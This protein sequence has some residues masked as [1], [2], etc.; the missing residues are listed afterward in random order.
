M[1]TERLTTA[2]KHNPFEDMQS[3][4]QQSQQRYND[5]ALCFYIAKRDLS[6]EAVQRGLNPET[7]AKW[8]AREA[9]PFYEAFR[10]ARS[11]ADQ[12][13]EVIT[14]DQVKAVTA[15][16]DALATDILRLTNQ[17]GSLKLPASFQGRMREGRVDPQAVLSEYETM[18]QHAAAFKKTHRFKVGHAGRDQHSQMLADF[19]EAD[20]RDLPLLENRNAGEFAEAVVARRLGISTSTVHKKLTEARRAAGRSR[21]KRRVAR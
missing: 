3:D 20:I 7:F 19:I 6:H 8:V 21:V 2:R 9:A 15:W 18:F 13:P 1:P 17:L 11:G 10:R 4:F 12:L 14:P 16:C 5:A